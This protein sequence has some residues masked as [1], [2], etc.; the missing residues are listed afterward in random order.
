M[1]I[2]L[3]GN[4]NSGK[5]T[6]FNALTGA[7]Q[8]IGNW[9]GVTI[10]QK[11]GYI[12]NGT[13]E[14]IDLPGI[15][16][17]SPYTLEEALSRAFLIQEKPDLII[18]IIDATSIERSLY[19]TT[20]LMELNI[21]MVI[22]LNMADMF[23]KKGISIDI[24]ALS[25]QLQTTI[26][27]ISALKRSG[28]KELVDI[29]ESQT[30]IKHQ[31]QS[32]F[33]PNVEKI[34]GHLVSQIHQDHARFIA[35]KLLEK[36][37]IIESVGLDIDKWIKPLEQSYQQDI[38][39]IIA[40]GRYDYIEKV[41]SQTFVRL[42]HGDHT[43]EL[44]DKIFLNKWLALPIFALIMFLIYYISVGVIGSLTVDFIGGNVSALS[45]WMFDWL[46]NIGASEWSASLVADGMIAGVGAVLNFVPQLILL[47]ILISLLE[48]T[49]Y[50]TRIA[51]FLDR[52]FK[53]FGLSG[54]SLIPFILGSGCSIP[55]IMATRTIEGQDERRISIM[56]TPFIPCSAKLPIIALFAGFFFPNYAGFVSFSLYVLSILIILLSAIIM[57]TFFFKGTPSAFI[58]ELP[59][60]KLPNLRYTVR[61]V[62][63]KIAE[64]IEKA[65]TI[66][67]MSSIIIWLLTSFSITLTYGVDVDES[68]L[69]YIGRVFS[70]LF[71]PM[72]GD[73]SWATSV[74]AIQGLVAKEQVVSSMAVI[75]GLSADITEGNVILNA[76]IYAF[77]TPASAY[78][79]MTF[80]LF[81][82]P[83]FGAIGA[84]RK[85]LGSA[86]K[87]WQAI[88]FQTGLAYVLS[89]VIYQTLTFIGG[90]L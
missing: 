58:S 88:L 82:A 75:G 16:S 7:N 74:S 84:M 32:I 62:Y 61:D 17:L 28:L 11:V 79:F 44:L 36:D 43:T 31:T 24:K 59:N 23:D 86:K 41:K 40:S 6:L 5:T 22:A 53:K 51:F 9:P 67:L 66:I 56:V 47:F 33:R 29:I 54:K 21:D 13:H 14:I 55:G 30:Y 35:I 63:D 18:N 20:Q 81:S 48:S 1:R 10:E 60:Y 90:L 38:E 25:E 85:E 50:M 52:L 69:A 71:Y 68:I 73:L 76:P 27:K 42:H 46:R 89:I 70:Y 4:Q 49:G 80:N 87:M 72:L 45:S 19:L 77:F 8:K 57:K 65:G 15:Y 26:V 39:T 83:C 12:S 34:I 2:A 78:A 37:P 3:I 64:F